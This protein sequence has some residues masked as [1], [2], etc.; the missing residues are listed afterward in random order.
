[1]P[2]NHTDLPT[3]TVAFLFTDLEGSTRLLA[4]LWGCQSTA[5]ISRHAGTRGGAH[6]ALEP[7]GHLLYLDGPGGRAAR[8]PG[9]LQTERPMRPISVAVPHELGEHRS[10]MLLVQHQQVVETL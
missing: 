8:R 10:Q 9:R 5:A 6:R 2:V 7:T 3:G 1:M 4:A